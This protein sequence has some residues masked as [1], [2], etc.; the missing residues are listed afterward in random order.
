VK[1]R[2]VTGN[3]IERII[4]D[5]LDDANNNSLGGKFRERAWDP[6]LVGFSS[7]G[8]PLYQKLKDDIGQ[9]YWTPVE[10]FLKTFPNSQAKPDE[11][12]VISWIL[13]QTEATKSDNRKESVHVSERWARSRIFGEE[14]NDNLRRNVVAKLHEAGYEAVAPML[15]PLWERRTS[16]KYGFASTWS[17]RHAAFISGLGT[18]GLSEG[19]ITTKGKA[20]R[21]GSAVGRIQIPAT[22]RPYRDHHE[23]CLFYTKKI[24][25]RCIARCPTG[26][27]TKEGHNKVKCE[28]YMRPKMDEYVRAHFGFEGYGCGLCQTRVP[29]ESKIPLPSDVDR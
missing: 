3:W 5:F 24:C 1:H 25:S 6:P 19:L 13:P 28:N 17:E 7:G 4:R 23:Y 16:E 21:C 22:R 12:A 14:I 15:S 26:A 8:D 10:I 2:V 18:F 9:F 27:I 29:C 11:L 20:M